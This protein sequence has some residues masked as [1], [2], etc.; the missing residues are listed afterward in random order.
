[1][2]YICP[3]CGYDGLTDQP[4]NEYGGSSDEICPS[5]GIQF[6]YDDDVADH[7]ILAR[8]RIWEEWRVKWVENGMQWASM[9]IPRPSDW[10]PVKQLKNVKGRGEEAL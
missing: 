1:M 4:W 3:I 2:E 8:N 9:G 10:D 7:D 5:C 6:G